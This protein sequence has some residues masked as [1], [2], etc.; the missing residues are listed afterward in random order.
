MCLGS[1][2]IAFAP[3]Y[4]SAGLAAPATLVFARLLQGFSV[5]GE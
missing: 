5:G 3:A 4:A 2:V 1:L